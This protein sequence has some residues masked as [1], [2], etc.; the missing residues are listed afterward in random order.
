MATTIAALIATTGE[1][2]NGGGLSKTI[3]MR[4]L[5]QSIETNLSYLIKDPKHEHE[6]PYTVNYDTGGVI[7]RTNTKN[8]SKLVVV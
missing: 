7:P 2:E 1:P 6:K 4:G 3:N 5:K 8:E